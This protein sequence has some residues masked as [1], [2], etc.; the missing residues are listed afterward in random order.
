M[1]TLTRNQ[2]YVWRNY[3]KAWTDKKGNLFCHFQKDNNIIC[4]TPKNVGVERFL[5]KLEKLSDFDLMHINNLIDRSTIPE[6]REFHRDT[7][8]VFQMASV[9]RSQ[10]AQWQNVSPQKREFLDKK[11]DEMEK[12]LG[13]R[14][15]TGVENAASGILEK[16]KLRDPS[17]YASDLERMH[18]VNYLTQQFFRTPKLKNLQ[19]RMENPYKD[20]GL[21]LDRTWFIESQIYALNISAVII[22]EKDLHKFKFI[23]NETDIPFITC[24]QPVTSLGSTE[25][26]LQFYYPL[27][28]DLAVIFGRD[29]SADFKTEINATKMQVEFYNNHAYKFSDNQVYSNNRDYLSEIVKIPKDVL[30]E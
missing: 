7:L 28:P 13:E 4:T 27:K 5:Y 22:L 26:S 8:D 12:T 16:L 20:Q 9:M 1:S 11:L 14:W 21:N 18:F 29:P 17:F 23:I 2:H 24:D 6:Q 19:M 15:H 30:S 3:L 10:L 25:K